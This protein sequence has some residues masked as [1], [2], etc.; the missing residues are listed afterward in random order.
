[1][2][3]CHRAPSSKHQVPNSTLILLLT[4]GKSLVSLYLN[5]APRSE[6]K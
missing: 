3:N 5:V 1:M 6:Q 2:M 4:L